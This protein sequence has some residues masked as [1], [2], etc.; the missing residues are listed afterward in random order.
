MN[1]H[2]GCVLGKPYLSG[3]VLKLRSAFRIALLKEIFG[4]GDDNVSS[5]VSHEQKEVCHHTI[6]MVEAFTLFR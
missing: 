1:K 4:S 5:N 6:S 2:S 3:L